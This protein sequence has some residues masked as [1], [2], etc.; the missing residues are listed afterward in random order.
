[1]ANREVTLNAP[2]V[3]AAE[4]FEDMHVLENLLVRIAMFGN[5]AF[6]A[7]LGLLLEKLVFTYKN[8]QAGLGTCEAGSLRP[9]VFR[10]LN[11]FTAL[12]R[13]ETGA[14]LADNKTGEI[15]KKSKRIRE[16][17]VVDTPKKK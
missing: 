5:P 15:L 14:D 3:P 4:I 6:R 7:P 9:F 8:V 12:A 11:E 10:A 16:A 13:K 1:M 2:P 17:A